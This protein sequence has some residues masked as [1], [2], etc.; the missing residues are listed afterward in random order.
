VERGSELRAV[1]GKAPIVAAIRP[2]RAGRTW[3]PLAAAAAIAFIGLG[4]WQM[5]RRVGGEAGRPAMRS[6]LAESLD[7]KI[8]AGPQGS[9]DLTWPA[10]PDGANY[11]VHVLAADDTSI[12]RRQTQEPRLSI[13]SG[14]LPALDGGKALFVEVEAFDSVGRSVAKSDLIALPK[15]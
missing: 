5:T 6:A 9:I 11:E 10:H 2:V 8:A 13:P 4:V 14:T 7:L 1:L 12:W 3:L 15:R